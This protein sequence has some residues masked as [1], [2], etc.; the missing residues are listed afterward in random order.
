[1]LQKGTNAHSQ[2]ANDFLDDPDPSE[3]VDTVAAASDS[4][5]Q[6]HNQEPSFSIP[7]FTRHKSSS[8]DARK[9]K[10]LTSQ[11]SERRQ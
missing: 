1:M 8:M 9:R 2:F 3:T 10:A 5:D 7:T 4:M 6:V 11:R